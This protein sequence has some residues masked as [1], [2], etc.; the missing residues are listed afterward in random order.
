MKRWKI[1]ILA[2]VI[3][4]VAAPPYACAQTASP[5]AALLAT[6]EARNASRVHGKVSVTP[7]GSG[8]MVNIM[9]SGPL[10]GDQTLTLM[11]GADCNDLNRRAATTVPLNAINGSVSRTLVAIP[12]S[13]FA[14][15]HFIVDV[16]DATSR[17]QLAESCA[18]P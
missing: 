11:S 18:R 6:L 10:L 8:S 4:T 12:F 15:R 14:S 7:Q 13:A 5:S 16:R 17:A 3:L 2:G 1:A 9:F